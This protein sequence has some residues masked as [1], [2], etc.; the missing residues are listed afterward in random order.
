MTAP[1]TWSARATPSE[2]SSTSNETSS[3]TAQKGKAVERLKVLDKTKG[4]MNNSFRAQV[5]NA[6]SN[7]FLLPLPRRHPRGHAVLRRTRRRSVRG[8]RAQTVGARMRLRS[9]L[10]RSSDS[11]KRYQRGLQGPSEMV[12]SSRHQPRHVL[13]ATGNKLETSCSTQLLAS[14]EAPRILF[15]EIQPRQASLLNKGYKVVFVTIQMGISRGKLKPEDFKSKVETIL[16]TLQLPAQEVSDGD[17]GA[18]L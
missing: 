10:R 1:S 17:V 5:S 7:T 2:C 18:P 8:L 6:V 13:K 14:L 12:S 3:S 4:G 16:K 15:T 9:L 11:S